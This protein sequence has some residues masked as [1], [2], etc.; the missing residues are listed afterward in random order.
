LKPKQNGVIDKSILPNPFCGHFSSSPGA[1]LFKVMPRFPLTDQR[2]MAPSPRTPQQ[3][4]H[5]KMNENP[6]QNE[7]LLAH[8]LKQISL[9]SKGDFL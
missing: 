3:S 5:N 6:W 8:P 2:R 4:F 9:E 7:S 1:Q